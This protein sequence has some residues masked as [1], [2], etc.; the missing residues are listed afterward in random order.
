MTELIQKNDVGTKGDLLS[1][2]ELKRILNETERLALSGG[3]SLKKAALIR[4]YALTGRRRG[5]ILALRVKDIDFENKLIDTHI[6]KKKKQSHSK[7]VSIDDKTTEMLKV[8]CKK[9]KKNDLV[10]GVSPVTAYR[11]VKEIAEK[12][13]IHKN[14]TVHS[15]RYS[16]ITLL[17]M[18]GY[19]NEQVAL[20]TNQHPQTVARYDKTDFFSI[21]N[22]FE[23]KRNILLGLGDDHE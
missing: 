11:W 1:Q 12:C 2:E 19:S 14:I 15:F 8:I 20:I 3:V 10:F 6:E 17:K 23:E 16:L 18:M 21:K 13:G 9:L 22:D 7:F 4:L 5:E